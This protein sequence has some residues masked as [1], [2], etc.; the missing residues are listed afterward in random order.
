MKTLEFGKA[1][2]GKAKSKKMPR[3]RERAF[4]CS[5]KDCS[6]EFLNHVAE[7]PG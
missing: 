5:V 1:G 2:Y 7:E 6:A 4:G 3:C